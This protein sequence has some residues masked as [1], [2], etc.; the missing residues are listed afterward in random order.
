MHRA[1]AL[2]CAKRSSPIE[3]HCLLL[4]CTY[5]LSITIQTIFFAPSFSTN[6]GKCGRK[7][8]QRYQ[9]G[10]CPRGCVKEFIFRGAIKTSNLS[11]RVPL[12]R[13]V[14]PRSRMIFNDAS[15]RLGSGV[16]EAAPQAGEKAGFQHDFPPLRE[17]T[18]HPPHTPLSICL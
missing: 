15:K 16:N 5:I 18:S 8:D 11:G 9:T 2:P 7:I 1:C 12:I 4:E 17:H 3:G 14:R 6:R 10:K 13:F